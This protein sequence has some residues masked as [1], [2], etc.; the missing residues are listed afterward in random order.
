LFSSGHVLLY[1]GGLQYKMSRHQYGTPICCALDTALA[2]STVNL[3]AVFTLAEGVLPPPSPTE[4][5]L[6]FSS[7]PL[8]GVLLWPSPLPQWRTIAGV[9]FSFLF[10]LNSGPTWTVA[11]PL[12]VKFRVITWEHGVF[13]TPSGVAPFV[14]LLAPPLPPPPP[15]PLFPSDD[16]G[17]A[18]S[19]TQ[20][21]SFFEPHFVR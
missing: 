1:S 9:V 14:S 20:T 4:R 21:Q 10:Y 5:N 19:S 6:T 18:F 17:F 8:V 16:L 12:M 7:T 15:P 2:A 3:Q 11:P 13:Y